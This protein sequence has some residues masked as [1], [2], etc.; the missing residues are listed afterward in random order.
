MIPCFDLFFKKGLDQPFFL[1]DPDDDELLEEDLDE[2][3]DRELEER[4]TED[5][6]RDRLPE[7]RY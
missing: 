5:L 7:L 4:D 1:L 3:R 2:E 6:D